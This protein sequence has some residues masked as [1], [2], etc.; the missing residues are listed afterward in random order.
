MFLNATVPLQAASYDETVAQWTSY[1]DVANWLEK[2]FTYDYVRSKTDGS[3]FNPRPPEQTFE[4][5]SGVCHNGAALAKDALNRIN[6]AYKAKFVFIKNRYGWP[7]HWVAACT[8]DGKL[9]IIDF[10]DG[11]QLQA[12]MGLHGPYDSLQ[13]Y[14]NFL[15]FLNIPGF[16]VELVEYRQNK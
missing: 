1:K 3:R 12:M 8:V 16:K 9:Y 2:Y 13:D 11:S 7:H 10:S 15:A 14:Q 6:S 4:L 5:R